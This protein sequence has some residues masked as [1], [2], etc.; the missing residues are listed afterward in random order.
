MLQDITYA[1]IQS[2]TD[3]NRIIICDLPTKLKKKYPKNIVLYIVKLLYGLIEAKNHWFA[4]YLDHHKK[5]LEMKMLFYDIYLLIT[6]DGSK[7]FGIVGIQMDNTLNVKI[8]TFM[9]KEE[10]DIMEAKFKAKT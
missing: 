1:Y 6:K 4:I 9:K 10:T 7:N 3:L 8:E 2:K 5:K